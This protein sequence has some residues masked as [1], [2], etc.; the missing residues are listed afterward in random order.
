MHRRIL[1]FIV[2]FSWG[3]AAQGSGQLAPGSG[4]ATSDATGVS[5]GIFYM[6]S[7]AGLGLAFD[8]S[9]GWGREHA[10]AIESWIALVNPDGVA[11]ALLL[12]MGD[13][14]LRTGVGVAT[15]VQSGE[16]GIGPSLKVSAGTP[17]RTPVQFRVS[18]QAAATTAGLVPSYHFVLGRWRPRGR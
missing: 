5:G 14:I 10:A 7:G 16:F 17:W 8:R 6:R 15:L 1:A 18:V 2:A 4:Q 9:I 3:H 11:G 12:G 13:G